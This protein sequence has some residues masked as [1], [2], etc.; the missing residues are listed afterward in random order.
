[1]LSALGV[2]TCR[3]RLLEVLSFVD[4]HGPVVLNAAF[5]LVEESTC[6]STLR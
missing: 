6:P 1:M 4:E 5:R 3:Q 2:R